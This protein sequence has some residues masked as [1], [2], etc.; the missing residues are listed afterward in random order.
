MKVRGAARLLEVL[1]RPAVLGGPRAPPDVT[2][3]RDVDAASVGCDGSCREVMRALGDIVKLHVSTTASLPPWTL[4]CTA[5]QRAS[6]CRPLQKGRL[7]ALAHRQSP[8]S[9]L[10]RSH[11]AV[12]AVLLL[13]CTP[14][15]L[16]CSSTVLLRS[17]RS[18]KGQPGSP[19]SQ[20]PLEL[21]TMDAT[22]TPMEEPAL[23]LSVQ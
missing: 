4:Q 2:V 5:L 22:M 9:P 11:P 23:A 6:L 15:L 3:L 1:V 19:S 12:R 7:A 16:L 14:L 20:A 17:W 8:S 21:A 13:H 10:P 18:G